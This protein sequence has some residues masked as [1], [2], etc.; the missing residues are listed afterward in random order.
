MGTKVSD[1]QEL[2]HDSSLTLGTQF[3][4]APESNYPEIRKQKVLEAVDGGVSTFKYVPYP[5]K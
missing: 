2:I 5:A 1:R 4:I 3:T